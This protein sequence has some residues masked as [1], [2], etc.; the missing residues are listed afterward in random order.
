M[1]VKP[2]PDNY[3]RITPY[4]VVQGAEKAIEFYTQLFGLTET[5]RMVGPD[6]RIGHAELQIGDS[7]IM[8]AD[9]FPE[10]D[11]RGPKSLGGSPVSLLIYVTDVDTTFPKAIAAGS[12]IKRPIQNQF[13]GDRSGTLTDPFGHTWTIAT[14]IENIATDEMQRRG[15]EFMKQ[16]MK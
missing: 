13:Y 8:L 14:R 7:T 3:R 11:I 1:A 2:S 10:M 6:G 12:E 15:E 5:M 4:L 16:E 9:E